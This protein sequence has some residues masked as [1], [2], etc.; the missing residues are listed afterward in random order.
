ME[1]INYK[2]NNKIYKNIIKES[3][4]S[5]IIIYSLSCVILVINMI[6]AYFIVYKSTYPF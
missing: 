5:Y 6:V 1:N 3:E 2:E 4:F